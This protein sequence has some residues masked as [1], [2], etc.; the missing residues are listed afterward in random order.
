MKRIGLIIF[1]KLLSYDEFASQIL[2]I[3]KTFKNETEYY[4]NMVNAWIVCESFIKHREKT[5]ALLKEKSL[6]KFTQN[7]AI[8]KCRDSF[9]VS[10]EDKEFLK[11]LRI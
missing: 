1:L 8:S 5:L 2:S 11:T 6:S 3:I 4:V 9:R 10:N 7:K